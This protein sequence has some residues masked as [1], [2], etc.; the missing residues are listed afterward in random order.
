MR[1]W[2]APPPASGRLPVAIR[3]VASAPYERYFFRQRQNRSCQSGRR[4][5][6]PHSSPDAA[7]VMTI[8][9]SH[10]IGTT[11]PRRRIA[12]SW[13]LASVMR[14][15]AC[16][17][18]PLDHDLRGFAPS[19]GSGERIRVLEL[20]PC[21]TATIV[22]PL[23]LDAGRPIDLIVYALP[24]GNSQAET[25][26]RKLVE[27]VGW[28][29]DIQ[30][31]GA[32]TRALRERGLR[33]AVVVYLE[34]DGKSWPAWRA[35][36][37]YERANARIVAMVDQLRAAIGNPPQL[38]VT[39]T[40]HSGGGS[41]MF[42]FVEG[43]DTLPDWLQ[44]MAFLD[45]NYNFEPR[46]G[47][48]IV[49][50]LRPNPTNRLVVLAYDDRE[51]MLDGKKVVSDSGG[52]WRATDRMIQHLSKSL[53]FAQDTAGA[54]TRYRAP[55]IEIVRHANPENKILHTAMIGEMNGYMHAMLVGRPGYD[56]G[57]AVLK[58]ARAYT[59]FVDS[60]VT[61][62]PAAP[63]DIPARA[64]GALSGRAFMATI[65][66]LAKDERE[67]ATRRELFAG[68]IPS[69]LRTLRTVEGTAAGAASV[70]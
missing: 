66:H 34:T 40:G 44:R 30:H 63:P 42:G 31:I 53:T 65:E 38:A 18:A 62:P 48:K 52:T 14:L 7:L 9:H 28:R 11:G 54:F 5:M 64:A 45:A 70:T 69:F 26:G 10:G 3:S 20:Y 59:P 50:W 29:Y 23:G 46:H 19:G 36:Q 4:P 51:I 25:I 22:A 60:G 68:N 27:G 32:Q 6:R 12:L 33:Q 24:N 8:L 49:A 2:G 39:L 37:G 61:L 67:A 21:V 55:Q 17:R 41:F 13:V 57:N 58:P 35:K 15:T 1:H 43:Q 56:R 16:A 47:D